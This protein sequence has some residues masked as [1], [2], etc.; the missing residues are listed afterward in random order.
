MCTGVARVEV[1]TDVRDSA[2]LEDSGHL[3]DGREW[4]V[5]MLENRVRVD[6]IE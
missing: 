4:V 5:D 6:E 3:R 2:W 1:N